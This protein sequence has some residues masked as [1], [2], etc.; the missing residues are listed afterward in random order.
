[1][2]FLNIRNQSLPQFFRRQVLVLSAHQIVI[3][4]ELDIGLSNLQSLFLHISAGEDVG[5]RKHSLFY[6]L[7]NNL[8]RERK[9]VAGDDIETVLCCTLGIVVWVFRRS[10]AMGGSEADVDARIRTSVHDD[11]LFVFLRE[12]DV[13]RQFETDILQ[14]FLH[15]LDILDE[16][17]LVSIA[18]LLEQIVVVDALLVFLNISL[19]L[20][21]SLVVFISRI[22]ESTGLP[23]VSTKSEEIAYEHILAAEE[24]RS[25]PNIGRFLE[26][27]DEAPF[28]CLLLILL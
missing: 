10:D 27:S 15:R 8:V 23:P 25:I 16:H 6:Q 4:K 28:F 20:Y 3:G 11:S 13:G 19:S 14:E 12:T 2:N 17:K 22:E 26:H 18:I 24:G 7:A 1:M 5:I 21:L 9:T